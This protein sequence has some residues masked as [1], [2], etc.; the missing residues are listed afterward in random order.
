M[1]KNT[2]PIV[3]YVRTIR[4]ERGKRS[5][6]DGR[7]RINWVL[8]EYRDNINNEYRVA[9]ETRGDASIVITATLREVNE[10]TK[11]W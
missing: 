4:V 1:S 9:Y 10:R 7:V 2:S 5:K 11:Q 8:C 6:H 3:H